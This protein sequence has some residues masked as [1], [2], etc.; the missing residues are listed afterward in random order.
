MTENIFPLSQEANA[1]NLF[2]CIEEEEPRIIQQP[3][4]LSSH[5]GT[6]TNSD[7]VMQ[8]IKQYPS[9]QKEVEATGPLP[10]MNT[11]EN[12][13]VEEQR[14]NKLF[15]HNAKFY[16]C[17]HIDIVKEISKMTMDGRLKEVIDV[18]S[19]ESNKPDFFE[20]VT[21]DGSLYSI[22]RLYN[23]G[24]ILYRG[25]KKEAY[26]WL[27]MAIEKAKPYQI[28]PNAKY[29]RAMFNMLAKLEMG[30]GEFDKALYYLKKVIEMVEIYIRDFK[31]AAEYNFE[32]FALYFWKTGDYEKAQTCFFLSKEFNE[33]TKE[34]PL[35][36][37]LR[38]G[39]NIEAA[40]FYIDCEKLEDAEQANEKAFSLLQKAHT[41]HDYKALYFCNKALIQFKRGNIDEFKQNFEVAYRIVG[42][43]LSQGNTLKDKLEFEYRRAF[44]HFEGL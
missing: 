42:N 10:P 39:L 20:C 30:R 15:A 25:Y 5:N 29:F 34:G 33:N 28:K 19:L 22:E 4:T 14:K 17:P 43:H 6:R 23:I 1:I 32:S 41:N 16:L 12:S 18:F 44:R 37:R 31:Y 26:E 35:K 3:P 8:F 24:F 7:L 38:I 21:K 36:D 11:E 40:R 27:K 9:E 13:L 2:H